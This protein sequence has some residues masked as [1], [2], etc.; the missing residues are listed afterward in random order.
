MSGSI[1]S[2]M[3][4]VLT[5][6]S[7]SQKIRGQKPAGA[8]NVCAHTPCI[9]VQYFVIYEPILGPSFPETQEAHCIPHWWLS[10]Q[11]YDTRQSRK[12]KLWFTL[13]G[14]VDLILG[15]VL[16]TMDTSTAE[17][18]TACRQLESDKWKVGD[19]PLPAAAGSGPGSMMASVSSNT[20]LLKVWPP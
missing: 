13:R 19:V 15:P 20:L 11:A 12:Q 9:I 5:S 3:P 16:S 14:L 10:W 17:S 2:K 6:L 18:G 4:M 1:H 7:S 8:G